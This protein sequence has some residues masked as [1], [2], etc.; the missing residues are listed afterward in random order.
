M[1]KIK[2]EKV[3]DVEALEFRIKTG[4]GYLVYTETEAE[5]NELISFLK[6]KGVEVSPCKYCLD[7]YNVIAVSEDKKKACQKFHL[8]Y[9]GSA[10]TKYNVR[11]FNKTKC[12][13]L[14]FKA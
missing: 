11:I 8:S 9:Y 6:S 12:F 1:N 14:Q 5:F 4:M 7:T 10:I 3:S 13:I 2:K